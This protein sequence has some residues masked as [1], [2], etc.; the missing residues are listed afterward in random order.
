MTGLE[1]DFPSGFVFLLTTVIQVGAVFVSCWGSVR[2]TASRFV[3]DEQSQHEYVEYK[4]LQRRKKD[5]PED[6][7][8]LNI[9]SGFLPEYILLLPGRTILRKDILSLRSHTL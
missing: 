4:C 7:I 2:I 1:L 6:I 9:S 8:P 3:K 5:K